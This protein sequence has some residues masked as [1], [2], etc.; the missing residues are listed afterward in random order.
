MDGSPEK[1]TNTKGSFT[2][3]ECMKRDLNHEAETRKK[4][5][6]NQM[7]EIKSCIQSK[8]ILDLLRASYIDKG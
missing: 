5:S 1:K 4:I 6:H 7:G 2:L 3:H 8:L